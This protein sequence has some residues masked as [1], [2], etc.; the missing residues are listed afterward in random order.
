MDMVRGAPTK[1]SLPHSR[2]RRAQGMLVGGG[3]S[4]PGG[5][6]GLFASAR[7]V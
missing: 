7:E 1:F 3:R 2:G 5:E 4:G 6:F